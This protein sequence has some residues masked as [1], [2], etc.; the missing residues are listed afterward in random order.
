MAPGNLFHQRA[1]YT[2]G[3]CAILVALLAVFLVALLFGLGGAS[4]P[5]TTQAVTAGNFTATVDDDLLTLGVRQGLGR[6]KDQ[7]PFTVKN[8]MVSTQAGDEIDVA[9]D[10]DPI[11]GVITPHVTVTIAPA[12]AAGKLDFRVTRIQ[13][14]GLNA[15]P[16]GSINRA[17]EDALNQQFGNLSQGKI[18]SGLNYQILA[19]HTTTSALVLTARLSTP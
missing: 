17:L 5:A 1:F 12:I 4:P 7:L 16:G 14:F 2:G 3:G 8:V 18:L 11:L 15:S 19:V 9:G 13:V 6:V 10:G